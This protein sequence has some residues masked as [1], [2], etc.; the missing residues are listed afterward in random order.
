MTYTIGEFRTAQAA[1]G[2]LVDISISG[3]RLDLTV[4]NKFRWLNNVTAHCNTEQDAST[5]SF[6]MELQRD[7]LSR[8]ATED[9]ISLAVHQVPSGENVGKVQ[10]VFKE[11]NLNCASLTIT[12]TADGNPMP[13]DDQRS[14]T[15]G[16]DF[17]FSVQLLTLNRRRGTCK[18]MSINKPS[19]D[20]Q[21][22]RGLGTPESVLKEDR[23]IGVDAWCE[24]DIERMGKLV[25]G[26]T[27][28][29]YLMAVGYSR[30]SQLSTL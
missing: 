30:N 23:Q 27:E 12:I 26:G 2:M 4:S 13:R 22:G 11:V 24:L 20:L 8:S 29:W 21:T 14:W 6:E 7:R 25:S 17:D 5:I 16:F 3:W 9:E 15:F 28:M 1:N 18:I 10:T 19:E